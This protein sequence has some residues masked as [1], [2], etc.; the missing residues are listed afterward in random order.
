MRQ[1]TQYKACTRV[2]WATQATSGFLAVWCVFFGGAVAA[3]IPASAEERLVNLLFFGLA[4]AFAFYV[5]GNILRHLLG[6]SCK[7]CELLTASVLRRLAGVAIG[8]AKLT[9]CRMTIGRWTQ[10]LS[11]LSRSAYFSMHRQHQHL[12]K[13]AFDLSCLL[14]RISARSIIKAQHLAARH[15]SNVRAAFEVRRQFRL[16]DDQRQLH[17]ER[18]V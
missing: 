16:A 11:Y 13:F 12:Y 17:S 18:P 10:R 2:I 15:R 14:I 3:F 1:A 5:S 6:F 9:V 4:P 7:L 8:C